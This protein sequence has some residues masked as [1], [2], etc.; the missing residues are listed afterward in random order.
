M[1]EADYQRAT[2]RVIGI[3]EDDGDI[4]ELANS[5]NREQYLHDFIYA[6]FE[7]SANLLH[8]VLSNIDT[9]FNK[10][11]GKRAWG[12]MSLNQV[13]DTYKAD[14][15]QKDYGGGDRVKEDRDIKTYNYKER[16]IKQTFERRKEGVTSKFERQII[17]K[18]EKD[19]LKKAQDVKFLS[20]AERARLELAKPGTIIV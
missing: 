17:E 6:K 14:E 5:N 3:L 8:A 20:P 10:D 16:I 7:N 19:E 13:L 18:Q 2:E 4:K 15:L 12:G 9:K 11:Y 1:S